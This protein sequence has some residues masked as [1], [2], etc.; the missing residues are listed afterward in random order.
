[1]TRSDFYNYTC[2]ICPRDERTLN[3]RLSCLLLGY[4]FICF[5]DIFLGLLYLFSTV[6]LVVV[7]VVNVSG[8]PSAVLL[9]DLE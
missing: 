9:V 8:P 6:S 3:V 5:V 7:G 2:C 4:L 1:M